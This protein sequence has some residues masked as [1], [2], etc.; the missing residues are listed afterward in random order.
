L[1]ITTGKKAEKRGKNGALENDFLG[2]K[3]QVFSSVNFV[4][5]FIFY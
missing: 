5:K 3:I 2:K 4:I 1:Q